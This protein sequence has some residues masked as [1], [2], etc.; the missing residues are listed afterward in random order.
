MHSRVVRFFITM[1]MN[2]RALAQ[3][4]II[5]YNCSFHLLVE[6]SGISHFFLFS[7]CWYC[8]AFSCF[9][10]KVCIFALFFTICCFSCVIMR[11]PLFPV[12]SFSFGT[13][14]VPHTFN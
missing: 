12:E 3:C 4:K 10:C 7:E 14:T 5:I 1:C 8:F 13:V 11:Y 2:S 6:L 9:S